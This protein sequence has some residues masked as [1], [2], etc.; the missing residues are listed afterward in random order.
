[1]TQLRLRGDAL[2]FADGTAG[3]AAPGA[4]GDGAHRG[5]HHH[6]LAAQEP[7]AARRAV[8]PREHRLGERA[9]ALAELPQPRP[10][11]QSRE[12]RLMDA[13]KALDRI[14]SGKD[15][16]GE[17]GRWA[18]KTIMSGEAT[19]SQ[20]GGFL[21]AMRVKGATVGEIAAAVAIVRD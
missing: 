7:A 16:P 11:L 18:M 21:M 14:G 9:R 15:L 3:N 2:P 19:P 1:R 20:I 13:K 17:E 10:R 4:G 8:P 12:G 6:G 5:R